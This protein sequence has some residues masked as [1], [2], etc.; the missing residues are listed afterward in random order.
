MPWLLMWR[1]FIFH[2]LFGTDVTEIPQLKSDPWL[3]EIKN[4][5]MGY[6]TT[7]VNTWV[8]ENK[9]K[10]NTRAG[11]TG[12]SVKVL[13]TKLEDLMPILRVPMMER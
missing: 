5:T 6:M 7:K 9:V 12:Q 3:Y 11:K 2:S 8:K 13:A 10:Q 1:S 4:A